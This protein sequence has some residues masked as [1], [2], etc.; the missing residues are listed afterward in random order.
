MPRSEQ[1]AAVAG[2]A[3][4]SYPEIF[5]SLLTTGLSE[6]RHSSVRNTCLFRT[7]VE[8]KSL[9]TR[10]SGQDIYQLGRQ[11]STP[12]ERCLHSTVHPRWTSL[13]TSKSKA[14]RSTSVSG[15]SR[16]KPAWTVPK[17]VHQD[18]GPLSAPEEIR[19]TLV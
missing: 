4:K 15:C 8:G 18:S 9:T 7:L 13:R 12:C 19:H 11:S 3:P 5:Q 6:K 10:S 16:Y 17:T 14:Q 1:I 2:A